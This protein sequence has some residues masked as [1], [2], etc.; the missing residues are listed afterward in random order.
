MVEHVKSDAFARSFGQR[1]RQLAW[2]LGAGVSASAGVPTA[3]NM[4]IEF[5]TYLYSTRMRIP[6]SEVD[7]SDPL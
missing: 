2:L 7:S 6:R 5:K 3:T 4:I 1:T